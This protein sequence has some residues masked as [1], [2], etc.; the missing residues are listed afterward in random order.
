MLV[1]IFAYK[2]A[3]CRQLSSPFASCMK[4]STSCRFPALLGPEMSPSGR[5]YLS[6]HHYNKGKSQN[7]CSLALQQKDDGHADF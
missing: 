1:L 3:H 5:P 4:S 6:C 2:L 7:Q